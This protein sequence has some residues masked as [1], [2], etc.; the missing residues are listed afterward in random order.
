MIATSSADDVPVFVSDDGPGGIV[1]EHFL[2][3]I[4]R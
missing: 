1:A 3:S 4:A 2:T